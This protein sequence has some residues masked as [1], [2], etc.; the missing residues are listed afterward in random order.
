M[1]SLQIFQ[2][3]FNLTEDWQKACVFKQMGCLWRASKSRLV[4]KVRRSKTT[5]IRSLK[6]RNIQSMSEWMKWVKI[7]TGKEF[8]VVTYSLH[9][10]VICFINIHYLN[11][12]A[13]SK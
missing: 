4:S 11:A 2:G 5:L 13:D 7:K 8:K 9:S 1:L 3:R 12:F 6:P 10:T